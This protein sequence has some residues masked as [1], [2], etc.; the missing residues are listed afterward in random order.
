MGSPLTYLRLVPPRSTQ[1][2]S[3]RAPGA[4]LGSEDIKAV[5][6]HTSSAID[7]YLEGA[8][9]QYVKRL[10]P[11]KLGSQPTIGHSS[12]ALAPPP[13]FP[14]WDKVRMVRGG[15]THACVQG[16]GR[17]SCGWPWSA[18]TSRCTS[19]PDA[20][21]SCAKC[22][23]TLSRQA[24]ASSSTTTTGCSTS[25]GSSSGSAESGASS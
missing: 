24:A 17:T 8:D 23:R 20:L 1:N 3:L 22:I 19:A 18:S 16:V 21:V 4:Q 13:S 14:D 7:G 25:S 12:A 11:T 9:F 5:A 15:K 10:L 2:S 6:R